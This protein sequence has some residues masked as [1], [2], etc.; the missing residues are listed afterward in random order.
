MLVSPTAPGSVGVPWQ[1]YPASDLDHALRTLHTQIIEDAHALPELLT[2]WASA[3]PEATPSKAIQRRLRRMLSLRSVLELA[4]AWEDA[5]VPGHVAPGWTSRA[6]RRVFALPWHHG[7]VN[8]GAGWHLHHLRRWHRPHVGP[9]S[10]EEAT[11]RT[12]TAAALLQNTGS[13]PLCVERAERQRQRAALA[14]PPLPGAA[15]PPLVRPDLDPDAFVRRV[16]WALSVVLE[17]ALV[18]FEPDEVLLAVQGARSGALA[19]SRLLP[20]VAAGPVQALAERLRT[21]AKYR[22]QIRHDEGTRSARVAGG[23]PVRR[24][25][26]TA[27]RAAGAWPTHCLT[28]EAAAGPLH[29]LLPGIQHA[30]PTSELLQ[31][32]RLSTAFEEI[33]DLFTAVASLPAEQDV[34]LP[35]LSGL[36][37]GRGF[38]RL[39]AHAPSSPLTAPLLETALQDDWQRE[40]SLAMFVVPGLTEAVEA[41]QAVNAVREQTRAKVKNEVCHATGLS[42]A[43]LEEA[44]GGE[45]AFDRTP[46]DAELERTVQWTGGLWSLLLARHPQELVSDGRALSHCVGWGGYAHAVRAGRSRIVRVLASGPE[47]KEPVPLLTLELGRD[48]GDDPSLGSRWHLVQARGASNRPPTRNE[49]ALLGLWAR[50]VGVRLSPSGEATPLTAQAACTATERLAVKWET[51]SACPERSVPPTS[52][53]LQEA[54]R[55]MAETLAARWTPDAARLHQEGLR[56]VAQ[57]VERARS[58]LTSELLRLHREGDALLVGSLSGDSLLPGTG[59]LTL[60]PDPQPALQVLTDDKAGPSSSRAIGLRINRRLSLEI[61]TDLRARAHRQTLD[62]RSGK[63]PGELAVC[64]SVDGGPLINTYFS[65]A[66]LMN[67]GLLDPLHVGDE[68]QGGWTWGVARRRQAGLTLLWSVLDEPLGELETAVSAVTRQPGGTLRAQLEAWTKTAAALRSMAHQQ[69][70]AAE[71]LVSR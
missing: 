24:S 3:D 6:A 31:E 35:E 20:D 15:L 66:A 59:A 10:W 23:C 19:L 44:T 32:N 58:H 25:A 13:A 40:R 8:V 7:P 42:E 30:G 65:P 52:Q 46:G 16:R 68:G 37:T 48:S 29:L 56:R 50:E 55:L 39:G 34:P 12:I 22:G 11:A 38:L 64:F 49:A 51:L 27:A 5:P 47:D 4:A 63:R 53:V 14:L 26:W 1:L 17:P 33:T 45:R 54:G 69:T 18:G 21:D 57:L 61:G 60:A 43:E 62:L 9:D 70:H 36:L 2:G 28:A 41:I 67:T 71:R